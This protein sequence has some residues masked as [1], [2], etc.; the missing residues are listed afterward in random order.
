MT[1]NLTYDELKSLQFDI[2]DLMLRAAASRIQL[3]PC[4]EKKGKGIKNE[5][6]IQRADGDN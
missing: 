2:A 3:S 5:R 4:E 1:M 6:K